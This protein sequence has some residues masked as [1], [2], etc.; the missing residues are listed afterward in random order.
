MNKGKRVAW[1]KHRAKKKKLDARKKAA[2]QAA[3]AKT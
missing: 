3:P 1:E 2:K